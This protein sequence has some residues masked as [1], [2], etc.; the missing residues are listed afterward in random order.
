VTAADEL[1]DA[2]RRLLDTIPR[3]TVDDA[4]LRE[5]AVVVDAVTAK[6]R[7][8]VREQAG[9]LDQGAFRHAYS[10]VTGTAHP[11]AP[12]V[13]V[14]V[15]DGGVRGTFRLAERHEGGP[16]LAHGGILCLVLDHLLGEAALAAGVGGMTVGLDVRFLAPTPL[17]VDLEVLTRVE[18][19]DGRKVRLVGEIRHDGTTTASASA[20]FVQLDREAATRLFPHLAQR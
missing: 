4:G 9:P 13:H 5:A 12:P 1:A 11:V 20:T 3:T 14:E 8:R 7:S 16:G 10:L 2:V 17:H 6:L 19:V 18:Q 15:V